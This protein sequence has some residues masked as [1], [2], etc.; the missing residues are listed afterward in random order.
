MSTLVLDAIA[1]D[2]ATLER[3]VPVPSEPLGYG[4]D[5]RSV[6]DITETLEEVDPFS[7]LGIAEACARRL[8]TPRGA[9]ADDQDYGID[10]RGY[11]NR[12]TT[13]A[14][15]LELPGQIRNELT[16]DDRVDSVVATVVLSGAVLLVT[17]RITPADPNLQAFALTLAVSSGEVLIEALTA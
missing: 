5:L 1:A 11:C 3:V 16:K 7:T 10:L 4:V 6:T 2:I 9:L 8:G 13:A 12:A 14:E 17:L 15:L